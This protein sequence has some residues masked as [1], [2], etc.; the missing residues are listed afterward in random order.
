MAEEPAPASPA[1]AAASA[2]PAPRAPRRRGVV[3]PARLQV[4]PALLDTPLAAGWQ[5][6][7]AM[8]I[9]L[10]LI[11]LLSLLAHAVLGLL[12]GATLAAL[13]TRR[14]SDARIWHLMR[15]ALIGLG[16]LVMA[17]SATR[18][19]GHPLVRSGAFN[20]A[21]AQA[22]PDLDPVNL[23]PTPT[24]AQWRRAVAQQEAQIARLTTANAALRDEMRGTS[25]LR[26][27]ADSSRTMGFTFGWAGVY[28][29][30]GTVLLRGRSVGKL[31]CRTRV[32]RLDGRP[33]SAMDA[34]ARNGGYAAG[35][36]TGLL[37]FARL[38][39]DPNRQAIQ[40]RI[41]GTVVVSTRRA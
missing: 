37:G 34:F 25:W 36:A 28:F 10:V 33:L 1:V 17:L 8:A 22:A 29:T 9:D 15:W 27:A 40:D 35:L 4:D 13:G 6:G 26:F 39:W 16:V 23:P 3:D 12:T 32:V 19:A 18:I 7:G 11:G 21:P 30:L 31:V 41:A 2:A 14:E 38:L 24:A 20:L 5:R